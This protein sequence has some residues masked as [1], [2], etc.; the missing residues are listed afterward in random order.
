MGGSVLLHKSRVARELLKE[1]LRQ[2]A[3]VFLECYTAFECMRRIFFSCN[4][5]HFTIMEMEQHI[6]ELLGPIFY[7]EVVTYQELI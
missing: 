5:H 7:L 2:M 3:E 1:K 4:T 6:N